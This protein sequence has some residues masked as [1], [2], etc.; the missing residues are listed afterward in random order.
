MATPVLKL[1]E[2]HGVAGNDPEVIADF[3]LTLASVPYSP[4]VGSLSGLAIYVE[5]NKGWEIEKDLDK[6]DAL[7]IGEEMS[8][9]ALKIEQAL[10]N[11]GSWVNPK[12]NGLS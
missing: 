12:T 9:N 6:S 7:W 5:A 1:W 11:G 4:Y 2:D 3:V 8:K 10:G